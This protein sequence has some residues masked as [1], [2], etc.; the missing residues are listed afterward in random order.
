MDLVSND[1][2]RPA[3]WVRVVDRGDG[4]SQRAGKNPS[5]KPSRCGLKEAA[6]EHIRCGSPDA[7]GEVNQP[8][9]R[10][11]R[12]RYKAPRSGFHRDTESARL[13]S[14]LCS[15]VPATL[16]HTSKL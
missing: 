11:D 7:R 6:G 9:W 2:T 4:L 13:T 16:G 3:R 5:R 1:P 15:F 8:Q 12:R 14:P 10:Y